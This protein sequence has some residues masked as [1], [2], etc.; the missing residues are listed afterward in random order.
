MTCDTYNP[1]AGLQKKRAI[2]LELIERDL[3]NSEI[4]HNHPCL[5]VGSASDF[6]FPLVS[7]CP[8][9]ILVDSG[10]ADEDQLFLSEM[11]AQATQVALKGKVMKHDNRFVFTFNFGSEVRLVEVR[12]EAKRFAMLT[13]EE[14]WATGETVSD[15]MWEEYESEILAQPLYT[16][17][18]PLGMIL[19]FQSGVAAIHKDLTTLSQLVSGGYILTDTSAECLWESAVSKEEEKL[20]RSQAPEPEKVAILQSCY[21]QIGYEFIPL[22]SQPSCFDY[23][24]L[25]KL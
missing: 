10:F 14:F 5:Y 22:E 16:A 9:Q 20:L 15:E 1:A 24:F 7:G 17:S 6:L 25:K 8:N 2:A 19:T 18:E 11:C 23:T 21:N 3:L 4:L 12:Y 13:K